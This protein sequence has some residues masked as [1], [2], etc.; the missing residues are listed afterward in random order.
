MDGSIEVIVIVPFVTADWS[1]FVWD[2]QLKRGWHNQPD[3][4]VLL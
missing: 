1:L 4:D 3:F 2:V